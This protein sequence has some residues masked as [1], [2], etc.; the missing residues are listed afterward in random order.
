MSSLQDR[1][2]LVDANLMLERWEGTTCVQTVVLSSQGDGVLTLACSGKL[3]RMT[4]KELGSWRERLCTIVE[5]TEQE[6]LVT[7][8]GS[9]LVRVVRLPSGRPG[10]SVRW[11]AVLKQFLSGKG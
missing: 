5:L 8:E 1:E 11:W 3:P 7:S 10:V 6:L 9:L 2:I 4:W